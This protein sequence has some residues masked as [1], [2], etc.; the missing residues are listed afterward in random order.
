MLHEDTRIYWH[1]RI[2]QALKNRLQDDEMKNVIDTV[3]HL[4]HCIELMTP[5]EQLELA[6]LNYR[7]ASASFA[8][9]KFVE[10]NR[11]TEIGIQLL[12]K[13]KEPIYATYPFYMHLAYS[14]YMCGNMD[15][16]HQHMAY[17]MNHRN[18]LKREERTRIALYQLEMFTLDN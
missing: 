3:D 17:L 7:A 18:Q 12:E 10:S 9:R 15:K 5:E 1:Y 13:F 11:Y 2:G 14:E 4:N 16:V 6:Q 8:H